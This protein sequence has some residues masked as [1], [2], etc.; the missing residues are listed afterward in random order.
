MRVFLE[1]LNDLIH[2]VSIPEKMSAVKS[3]GKS[4]LRKT[5]KWGHSNL[6]GN[7]DMVLLANTGFDKE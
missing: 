3:R 2:L 7:A 5:L 6:N 4:S 1:E